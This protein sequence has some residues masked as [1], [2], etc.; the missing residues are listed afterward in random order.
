MGMR[1]SCVDQVVATVMWAATFLQVRGNK[2]HATL[3]RRIS[4]VDQSFGS[5]VKVVMYPKS[6]GTGIMANTL[7]REVSSLGCGDCASIDRNGSHTWG[8]NTCPQRHGPT[9]SCARRGC[10]NGCSVQATQQ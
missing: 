1:Q 6:S 9:R 10:Q 8:L 5:Q 2:V 7:M 4:L 3:S